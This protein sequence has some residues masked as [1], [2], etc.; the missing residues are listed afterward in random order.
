[1][2]EKVKPLR[3]RKNGD[4]VFQFEWAKGE[5]RQSYKF[6]VLMERI[7]DLKSQMN[8]EKIGLGFLTNEICRYADI[9]RWKRIEKKRGVEIGN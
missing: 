1:M 2:P 3:Q 9:K 4:Y 8:G 6:Q 5:W 7:L